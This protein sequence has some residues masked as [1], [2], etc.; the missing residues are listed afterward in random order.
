M[1]NNFVS[2]NFN[3]ILHSFIILK[4]LVIVNGHLGYKAS[5]WN[6]QTR[7]CIWCLRYSY[8]ILNLSKTLYFL[9]NIFLHINGLLNLDKNILFVSENS[10]IDSY[11]K[12]IISSCNQ[13]I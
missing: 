7:L 2:K 10:Y 8:H 9:R 3:K 13:F 5:S 6:T 11:L 12:K 1:Y 4:Q